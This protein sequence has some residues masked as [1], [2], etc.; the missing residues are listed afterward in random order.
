MIL[1]AGGIAG[2]LAAVGYA[3]LI[4]HGLKTWWIGAIGTRF[5]ELHVAAVSLAIG[6]AISLLAWRWGRSGGVSADCRDC[7]HGDYCRVSRNV[8]R[9]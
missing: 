6:L 1:L 9:P 8:P 3:A 4:I 7:R 5:L 2:V